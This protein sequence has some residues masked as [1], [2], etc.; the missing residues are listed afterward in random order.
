MEFRVIRL[1]FASLFIIFTI[2]GC[3]SSS[4][5]TTTVVD[6]NPRNAKATPGD[7]EVIADTGYTHTVFDSAKEKCQHCHNDLYDTWTKS[8]HSVSWKGPIFQGQFQN[9]MR[10]RIT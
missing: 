8:G 9:V 5:S 4:T 2:S 7:A 3:G 6:D 1:I 10:G